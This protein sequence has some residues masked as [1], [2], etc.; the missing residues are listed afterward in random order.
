[1]IRCRTFKQGFWLAPIFIAAGCATTANIKEGKVAGQE[2]VMRVW[3]DTGSEKPAYTVKRSALEPE[4]RGLWDGPAWRAAE[5]L[6][7]THYFD[8]SKF[9]P[10][11]QARALYD[12]EGIYLH[13]RV[14]DQY[15]LTTRTEYRGQV[16]KDSCAEFFVQPKPD[17]GYFNFEINSGGTMLA[18]FHEH[19]HYRG[20]EQPEAVPWS[21]A[22][23]IPLY[24]S[25]PNVLSPEVQEPVMWQLEY[26]IPFSFFESFV[27]PLDAIKGQTWRANF[28]K[29]A[30][31][32]SHPHWGAWSPVLEDLNF[33][34]PRFFGQLNFE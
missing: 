21:L 22:A 27:G 9:K 23:K 15:V 6:E 11:V 30:E 17:R 4:L 26:F 34:Q 2:D 19:P 18:S 24:H 12:S 3:R 5:T 14:E 28:Y 8:E 16:W 13:F 31:D 20:P 25:A 29:C 1:M 10:K 33:H 32:N 7:I